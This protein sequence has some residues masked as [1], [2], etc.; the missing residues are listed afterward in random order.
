MVKD[1]RRTVTKLAVLMIMQ[2]CLWFASSMVYMLACAMIPERYSSEAAE[3][4][5]ELFFVILYAVSF[6]VPILVGRKLINREDRAD[7]SHKPPG[8]AAPMIC[9]SIGVIFAFAYLNAVVTKPFDKIGFDAYTPDMSMT[10]SPITF[11]AKFIS[12]VIVPALLEE[13]L[14]R[15]IA[16]GALMP[17]GR[18]GAVVGSALLFAVMHQNPKQFLYAFAAGAAIGYF[19]SETGSLALGVLIHTTNNFLSL[20]DMALMNSVEEKVLEAFS[21]SLYFVVFAAA[22]IAVP[23]LIRTKKNGTEEEKEERRLPFLKNFFTPA[24]IVYFVMS[25]AYFAYVIMFV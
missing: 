23:V 16:L 1:Y 3:C 4:L 22:I 2:F 18:V 13:L 7:L 25:A 17:Y 12:L 21:T 24:M 11:F 19:V 6:G 20:V 8:T 10:L 5:E 9:V 15:G 14:F